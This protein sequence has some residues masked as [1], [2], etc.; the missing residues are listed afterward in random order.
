MGKGIHISYQPGH[1]KH[2]LY[3]KG[4]TLVHPFYGEAKR[5]ETL[6]NNHWMQY[7]SEIKDKLKI[8]IADDCGTPAIHIL[9]SPS[10]LKRLDINLSIYRILKDLK[11]NTPGALNLGIMVADTEHVLIMDSDCTFSDEEM[12]KIMSFKP[13]R[14]WVYKF[15]RNRITND[16]K[17]KMNTRYLPCTMLFHK[18]MF[19]H[20]NGFDEDF[21]GE[22]SGGYAFFDN[23]FDFKI[24]KYNYHIGVIHDITATEY[25][26]DLVG[27]RV[28][29]T[30]GHENINRQLRYDKQENRKPES[31]HMLRF[32]WE[33]TFC[34]RRSNVTP[35]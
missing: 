1:G 9:M 10:K 29:R 7:R 35:V 8:V 11:Y 6:Y 25:M 12:H 15:R 31:T 26:D 20:I 18:D 5:F 21:T 17:W 19:L 16:S 4:L 13:E 22:Y 28:F 14:N 34:N 23:H 24:L 2:T 30:L 3:E 32:S 33:R 27:N